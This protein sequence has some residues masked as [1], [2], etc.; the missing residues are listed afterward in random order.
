MQE[1]AKTGTAM[2]RAA[3]YGLAQR[4]VARPKRAP[5]NVWPRPHL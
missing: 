4:G 1:E 5:K 3:S 2:G